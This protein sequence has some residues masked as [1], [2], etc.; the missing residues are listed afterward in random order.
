MRFA[1][2][3]M[4]IGVS[5]L[6]AAHANCARD[7]QDEKPRVAQIKDAKARARAEDYLQR[8]RRELDENEEFDCQTAIGVIDKI[9]KDQPK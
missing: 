8:A 5:W 3:T 7:V 6:T 4:F 2:L 9:I 1:M